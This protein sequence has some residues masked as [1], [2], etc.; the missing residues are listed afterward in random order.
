[1]T[2]ELL[3][4]GRIARAHGIHGE[5]A[6]KTLTEVKDRFAPGA[7]VHH[8]PEG[9]L[10]L[11]VRSSRPFKDG[12]LVRFEEVADRNQAE[13]LRG[14]LLLTP[15]GDAPP[16]P[17]G[18]YWEH[19]MI[20]LEVVTEEGRALGTIIEIAHNPANDVWS[21]D[22]GVLIPAVRDFVVSVDPAAGK[23]VIRDIPG[24]EGD[25]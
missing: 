23:V 3:A 22:A 1:M 12:L 11:T 6:V 14:T 21:T 24:L 10:R 8:G 5:V 20:G 19:E 13:A 17:E 18:S 4:V 25:A 16:L 9:E 7:V 2:G 15:S